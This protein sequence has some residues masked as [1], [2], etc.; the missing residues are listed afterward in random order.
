MLKIKSIQPYDLEMDSDYVYLELAKCDF[1]ILF[2]RKEYLFFP[3]H[4]EKIIINRDS[5]QIENPNAIFAFQR[6]HDFI[7]ITLLRL[8]QMTDFLVEVHRI[9]KPYY[10]SK[11]KY[12]KVYDNE[13]IIDE[14]EQL[15]KKR[16]IDKALDQRDRKSFFELLKLL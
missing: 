14:L 13:M 15:N 5:R 16:L 12:D 8:I 2:N 7:Y 9:A 3:L 6:N 4:A 1:R 11:K 10:N